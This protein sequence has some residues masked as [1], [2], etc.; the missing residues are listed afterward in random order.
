MLQTD[1]QLH[2]G[3][4]TDIRDVL[5]E[6]RDA[7][8][9]QLQAIQDDVAEIKKKMVYMNHMSN[10]NNAKQLASLAEDYQKQKNQVNP[11]WV[12]GIKLQA[13][14]KQAKA[15]RAKSGQIVFRTKIWRKIRDLREE[16]KEKK[17]KKQ[18][19]KKITIM[20]P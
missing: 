9:E 6:I 20:E 10:M 13:C 11:F 18:K 15:T 14:S 12:E 3:R 19:R 5:K 4:L 16:E 1:N 2:A 7:N 8:K 17:S